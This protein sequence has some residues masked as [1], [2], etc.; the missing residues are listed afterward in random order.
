MDT[1]DSDEYVVNV[2]K[3]IV[4][5]IVYSKLQVEFGLDKWNEMI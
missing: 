5:D 2:D 4:H 1:N 3:D